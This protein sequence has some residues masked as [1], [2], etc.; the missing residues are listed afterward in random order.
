MVA[1]E[2][3]TRDRLIEAAMDLFVYR[4]YERT[5]LAD[6]AAQAG[7][8]PGS[9][10]HFFKTKE[11]LLQAT[12]ERRKE[13]LRSDVLDPAWE[14]TA[15]PIDRVFALLARYRVMLEMTDFTHGC[16]IGN[17]TLEVGESL[18]QTRRLLVEN[19][20]G[21]LAAIEACFRDAALS[22][23]SDTDPSDLA[24]FV[25]TTLE[26]AV[27]LARTYRSFAAYDA[28]IRCL[29]DYVERLRSAARSAQPK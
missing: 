13:L 4:G 1:N 6:V 18:P 19:F 23:P 25:L 16:P 2:P 7:A 20:D 14:Q 9:L 10:Y 11:Q 17:L 5:S 12:L 3:G 15:D 24:V 22:L 21:W 8:K 27:M 29:R 26:G 28:A